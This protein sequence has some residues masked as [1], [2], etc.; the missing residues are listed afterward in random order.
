[1]RKL[2]RWRFKWWKFAFPTTYC[3]Q[4]NKSNNVRW[5]RTLVFCELNRVPPPP[6]PNELWARI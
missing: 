5:T 6:P 3:E 1:M 4:K 2:S